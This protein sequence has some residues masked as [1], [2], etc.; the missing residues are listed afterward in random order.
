M[1][2]V[3]SSNDEVV[4]K[5]C[6]FCDEDCLY[7][8]FEVNDIGTTIPVI[9]CN[10]CKIIFKVENDS[11]YLEDDKTYEYLKKKNIKAWNNRKPLERA[12]K[13]LEKEGKFV[14]EEKERCATESIFQFDRAVGYSNGIFNAIEFIKGEME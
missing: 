9:F 12:I 5:R 8:T 4:L 1:N 2:E 10:S 3:E 13:H 14:D 7:E 11:P 6:P